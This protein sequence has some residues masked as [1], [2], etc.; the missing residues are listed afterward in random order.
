M[1]PTTY[2]WTTVTCMIAD[3][4]I[5]IKIAHLVCMHTLPNLTEANQTIITTVNTCASLKYTLTMSTLVLNS[6]GYFQMCHSVVP[7]SITI[8]RFPF[9]HV[10]DCRPG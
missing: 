6:R 2:I 5:G 1:D 7:A 8:F 4:I 3:K 9:H 10:S